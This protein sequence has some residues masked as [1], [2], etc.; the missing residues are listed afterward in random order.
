M[1][2]DMTSRCIRICATM[3]LV[4]IAPS[5]ARAAQVAA[6]PPATT[7]AQSGIAGVV[8]DKS[9]AVL[10]GEAASP[11]ADREGP[12][13]R[14]QRRGQYKIADLPPGVY[15]I[16]FSLAGFET[17]KREGVELPAAFTATVDAGMNVGALKGTVTVTARERAEDL[18][19]VPLPLRLIPL[20]IL[21]RS[22]Y[23]GCL[24]SVS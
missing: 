9:G 1:P 7:C 20:T 4:A 16:T 5:G 10:P 19:K 13:R 11:W 17:F 14:N 12:R 2:D 21:K 24:T 3:F 18:Q 22:P 8:K 15:T 23:S 6:C